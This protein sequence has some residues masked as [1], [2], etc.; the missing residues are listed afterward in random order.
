MSKHNTM[1][2]AQIEARNVN[3][4]LREC[5]KLIVSIE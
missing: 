3:N 2:A 1:I 4:T 5:R